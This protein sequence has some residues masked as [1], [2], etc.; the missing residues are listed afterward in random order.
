MKDKC[1]VLKIN[2]RD[3]EKVVINRSKSIVVRQLVASYL[4]GGNQVAV[5]D[6]DANDIKIVAACLQQL[7][8]KQNLPSSSRTTIDVQ[9]C[10]TAYRF[11]TAVLA[12]TPGEWLLT[13][14]ER[15]RQRPILPLVN[16]LQSIG[17]DIMAVPD[18]LLIS[19][20][21]LQARTVD[22]DCSWSSQFAS[23]LYMIAPLINLQDLRIYPKMPA[24]NAYISMTR[25]VVDD[26]LKNRTIESE[27]DWSAAVFWYLFLAASKNHGSLLLSD[28]RLA[29]LQKDSIVAEWFE[30]WGIQSLQTAEGV[31]IEKHE[32]QLVS[33]LSLD[34][35]QHID[36][37]PVM[38]VSALLLHF[39]LTMSGVMNLDRKESK[40]LT[41]LCNALAPYVPIHHVGEGKITIEGSRFQDISNGVNCF[42][43]EH[44][45]RLVMAYA[46][47]SLR[48]D[49]HLS[50]IQCVEKSYPQLLK[51]VE[52]R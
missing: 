32:C 43:V 42:H 31:L 22:I 23:A 28:L 49:V 14:T 3:G 45:H 25:Q 16:A 47:L 7:R 37:A 41:N 50:D 15:L 24:S 4:Y 13:G 48:M 40:R 6:E 38:A 52:I 10:G 17:A 36:L 33:H 2:V 35:S 27:S 18:G 1:G 12:V 21:K 8:N 30:N 29:S 26:I 46:L 20:K 11:F 19:G 44:D 51:Y 9:D 5:Y 39:D 34:F